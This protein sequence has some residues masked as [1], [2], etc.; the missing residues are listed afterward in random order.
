MAKTLNT[1]WSARFGEGSAARGPSRGHIS[2]KTACDLH[3]F[4]KQSC[5]D[6]HDTDQRRLSLNKAKLDFIADITIGLAG[7]V[8]VISGLLLLLPADLNSGILGGGLRAWSSLHTW[9]SLA[10]MVGVGLH[11]ALHWSWMVAM[12]KRMVLPTQQRQASGLGYTE[13]PGTPISRRAFLSIGG[14]V[15]VAAGLAAAGY[16]ALASAASTGDGQTISAS[17]GSSLIAGTVQTSGVAC[18]RGLV[19]DPSPGQCRHFID[20]DGDGYC[21]YSVAGSGSVTAGSLEGGFSQRRG[22]L[23]RP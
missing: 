18:P 23:G 15:A 16:K 8:S 20:S 13:P 2:M 19:N 7:L 5:Y 1:L 12:A 21:D 11:L 4:S 9:S 3:Q 6:R 17:Q 22:G 10:A 14:A